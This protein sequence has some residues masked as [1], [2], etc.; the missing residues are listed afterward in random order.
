M[1][2]GMGRKRAEGITSVV[3]GGEEVVYVQV[4]WILDMIYQQKRALRRTSTE[5]SG[6]RDGQGVVV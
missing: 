1:Q 2:Y 3:D 6:V 4:V 5:M